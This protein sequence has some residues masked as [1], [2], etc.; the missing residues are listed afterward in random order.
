MEITRD[1]RIVDLPELRGRTRVF[2][3]RTDAGGVVAGMLEE[4]RGSGA[5]VLA[6]PAGGVPVGAAISSA[7]GLPFDVAV[8]SKITPRWNSEVGYGAVAWNGTVR[9]NGV[10]V[11]QM[12][13]TEREM[14]EDTA[15]TLEKVRRRVETLRGNR[16]MPELSGRT[17]LLVDDG[18]ASGFTMRVAVEAVRELGA[19][20]IVVAVPTA[21]DTSAHLVAAEADV[22]YCANLRSGWSFA[23]A[24]AYR[25]WRDMEER[26]FQEIAK[27]L[28]R[29]SS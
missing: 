20:P 13:L 24:D 2:A 6:I 5:I 7:L 17:V 23:V 9:R 12:G 21:H 3:D 26:E 22:V 1:N 16:P 29:S 19:G 27:K 4:F 25:R 10:L 8:V 15:R 28:L 18:L 11:P 14:A